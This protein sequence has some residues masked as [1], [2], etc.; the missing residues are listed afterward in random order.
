MLSL[1]LSKE[2][3]HFIKA[4]QA[5]QF[6]QVASKIFEL[7]NEPRP[8]DFS[9]LK[10]FSYLRADVG[11]YRI[12]YEQKETVLRVIIIGKRNDDEV[13]KKLKNLV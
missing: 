4:L 11:E 3:Y 13:Y 1:D 9:Q 7:L 8:Q 2:A 12:I 5:K 6:K 10:G